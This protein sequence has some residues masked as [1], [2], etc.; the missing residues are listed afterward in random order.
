MG[1]LFRT[2]ALK[3]AAPAAPAR[4]VRARLEFRLQQ[5]ER[6]MMQEAL[7]RSALEALDAEKRALL[8]ELGEA[9]TVH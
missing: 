5:I 7:T 4:S 2:A 9:A 6:L 1:S 3:R 8:E